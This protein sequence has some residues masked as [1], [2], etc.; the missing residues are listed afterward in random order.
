MR[1]RLGS[2]S[3]RQWPGEHLFGGKFFKSVLFRY[4]RYV[5]ISFFVFRFIIKYFICF[6]N[7][8]CD[9][10]FIIVWDFFLGGGGIYKYPSLLHGY[11]IV[12]I[13]MMMILVNIEF[14]KVIICYV[15]E[16]VVVLEAE[17]IKLKI[18]VKVKQ[19]RVTDGCT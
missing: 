7:F 14:G 2:V 13:T 9:Y 10:F 17:A 18:I 6:L 11:V 15:N 8:Y 1:G 16:M 5:H 19:E 3:R 4:A 12:G